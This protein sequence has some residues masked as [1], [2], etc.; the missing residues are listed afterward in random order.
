MAQAYQDLYQS[1]LSAGTG[2]NRLA[3]PSGSQV[4]LYGKFNQ[5]QDQLLPYVDTGVIYPGEGGQIG[6]PAML[7]F[8]NSVRFGGS[9][10]LYI[11]A[12]VDDVPIASGSVVLAEDPFQASIFRLPVGEAVGYG[13]RL[14]MTGL[15]WWR[16]F[17]VM[18][19]PVAPA[20][21]AKP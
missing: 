13:I 19:E 20:S 5:G 8:F 4:L 10:T 12:L 21:E 1:Y 18:W 17:E 15:A 16:Y 3:T 11:R 7:R 6:D 9:G 2:F 14:Q